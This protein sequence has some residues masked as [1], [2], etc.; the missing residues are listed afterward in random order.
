M[1]SLR[2]AAL[3]ISVLA[4]ASAACA[5]SYRAPRAADGHADL[6]GLW[7]SISLTKLERPE[8]AASLTLTDA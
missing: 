7:T 2:R 4:A 3:V 6:G 1:L 8:W 5:G